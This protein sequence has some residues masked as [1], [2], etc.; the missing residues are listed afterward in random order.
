[1]T[2]EERD[3]QA[4]REEHDGKVLREQVVLALMTDPRKT[5]AQAKLHRPDYTGRCG[6][7]PR[8]MDCQ[9]GPVAVLA[10]TKLQTLGLLPRNALDA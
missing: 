6:Y 5:L 9:L 2:S 3:K 8:T 10:V 4:L 1:M 7:C